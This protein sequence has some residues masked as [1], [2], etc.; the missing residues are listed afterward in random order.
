[1]IKREKETTIIIILLLSF[2]TPLWSQGGRVLT[3]GEKT[4]YLRYTQT[5]EIAEFLSLL[6][7]LSPQLNVVIAGQTRPVPSFDYRQLFLAIINEEGVTSPDQL[8]RR[9]PTF[10]IFASQH[11]NEQSGKEAAL[12]IIRDLTIGELRPLLKKINFLILPQSNPYGNWFDVRVNEQNLDL[13]RDHVKLEAE[14]TAV[15][16]RI[17]STWT[18]EITLD[19]H[20]KGDDYYRVSIGC[21]SNLNIHPRLQEFSRQVLLSEVNKSLERRRITFFE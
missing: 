6:D 20:E 19:L 2:V 3:P 4:N 7:H 1:M 13:N 14:E 12:Q 10:F 17:F 16:H 5:E 8:N 11:G 15:I 21:V 9:R 18:P